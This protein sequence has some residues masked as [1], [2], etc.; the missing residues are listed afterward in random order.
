MDRVDAKWS[1]RR[2][3]A[4]GKAFFRKAIKHQHRSR[5]VIMLDGCAA[6]HRAVR[7]LKAHDSLPKEIMLRSSK[8][9]NNVKN[10]KRCVI[11]GGCSPQ[12]TRSD[13]PNLSKQPTGEQP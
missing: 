2:D 4:A 11:A 1:A 3:I 9:L 8:Y 6:S 5:Q 10:P 12:A 7:E 13:S